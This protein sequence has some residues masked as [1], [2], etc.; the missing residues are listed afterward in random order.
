[1]NKKYSAFTLFETL[2]VLVVL[3]IIAILA[4]SST[5][6]PDYINEKKLVPLSHKFYT[7]AQSAYININFKDSTNGNITGLKDS[8]GDNTVN[9]A[10]LASYFIKYMDGETSSCSSMKAKG[11]IS[12]Y[13]GLSSCAKFPGGFI[14]GFYYNKSCN[15]SVKANE[16]LNKKDDLTRT[17]TN[18]CGFIIYQLNNAK[19]GTLGSDTFVIPLLKR[20][21]KG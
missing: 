10:D 16:Y 6:Q 12:T 20:S 3:G 17:Q 4:L 14:A 7:E 15:T 11:D 8:N 5:V 2:L 13:P 1:M 19:N 18:S 9:S 21:I